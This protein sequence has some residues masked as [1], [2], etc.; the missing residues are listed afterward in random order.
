MKLS[1]I[2]INYNNAPGLEATI[3]SVISQT[4][5]DFEYIIIDGGSKDSSVE[6][7]DKYSRYIH[8][9]VSEKDNGVYDAMNKGIRVSGGEYLLMLNS[10]D[11]LAD[12]SILETVFKTGAYNQDII[13]GDVIWD[14]NGEIF[15][16]EKYPENLSFQYFRNKSLGHQATFIKKSLHNTVAYYDDKLKISSDWKFFLLSICKYNVSFKHIPFSISRCDCEGMSWSSKNQKIILD[17]RNGVFEEYFPLFIA[18]YL[19]LDRYKS[20]EFGSRLNS[21]KS[22]LKS[23]IKKIIKRGSASKK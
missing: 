4:Y 11:I 14:S 5:R 18:D 23:T 12:N 6:I 7:I 3:K 20:K 22:K 17:E 10:G 9:W 1:I 13:Y 21:A 16:I 8:F 19:Q 2:T 15:M